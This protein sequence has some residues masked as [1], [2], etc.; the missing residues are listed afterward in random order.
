MTEEMCEEGG[1][2]KIRTGMVLPADCMICQ[3]LQCPPQMP[4]DIC[5][6]NAIIWI[7]GFNVFHWFSAIYFSHRVPTLIRHS[8]FCKFSMMVILELN[9]PLLDF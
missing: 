8:N 7:L 4:K 3:Q 2:K 5:I 9:A 6:Q 1:G